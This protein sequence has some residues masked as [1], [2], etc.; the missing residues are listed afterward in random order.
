MSEDRAFIAECGSIKDEIDAYALKNSIDR[1][2]VDFDLIEIFTYIKTADQSQ[3]SETKSDKLQNYAQK[4][5]WEDKTFQI[6]QK[7]SISIYKKEKLQD[8]GIEIVSN[9]SRTKIDANI[10]ILSSQELDA[11]F[12]ENLS[13]KLIKRKAKYGVLVFESDMPNLQKESRDAFLFFQD[14]KDSSYKISLCSL[15][16]PI[17]TIDGKIEYLY[18][19]KIK[20]KDNE[21]RVDYSDRGFMIPI[22][23]DEEL[24]KITKPKKGEGYRDCFGKYIEPQ[25]PKAL[26]GFNLKQTESI[27][28]IEDDSFIIYRS[29]KNGY[30]K[31]ENGIISVEDFMEINEV[32]FKNT[33]SLRAG[34][35]SGMV[36]KISESDYL[37]ESIGE[38][39]ILE[40]T[41]VEAAGNIGSGV[42][43][44]AKEVSIGGQTHKSSEIYAEEIDI[45]I[46][47]GY[48]KGDIVNIS[49]LEGGVVESREC[50]V[51]E[52]Q[53]GTIKS[54]KI[55]I[56][57]LH[58]NS[59]I[60]ATSEI[61]IG[62]IKGED[63]RFCIDPLAYY[64][65]RERIGELQ[66]E[67]M[68]L[69]RDLHKIQRE[70]DKK[71][72]ILSK[73][74]QTIK[75]LRD[76]IVK[77]KSQ[78]QPIPKIF[79]E[80]IGAFKRLIANISNLE[81]RISKTDEI[82]ALLDEKLDSLNRDILEAKIYNSS[83]WIGFNEIKF[84]VLNPEM[85]IV[86]TPKERDYTI[87][88][89]KNSDNI[90]EIKGE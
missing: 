68:E 18:E 73:N 49:R 59:N 39:L 6:K 30:V 17:L 61:S 69:Q 88:L 36:V 54:K 60:F 71:R 89:E 62:V 44:Y 32:S 14:N 29:K 48:C 45:E 2:E 46:H 42:K 10:K 56:G 16:E 72:E 57:K 28:K 81:D 58:S 27:E 85:E 22:K 83:P 33:G 87:W 75:L 84:R 55:E 51:E 12:D 79:S 38:G 9:K 90:Y 4:E 70:L 13:K 7:Y 20:R 19:E 41:K 63:N 24:I 21:F 25:E 23:K 8:D 15:K 35:D 78:N 26:E 65:D 52:I 80:K 5:Y 11:N 34:V 31:I 50:F 74:R 66:R 47:K 53:S 1:G 43:I 40:V 82:K 3:F 37:K 67:D 86:Y 77:L 76:K 64:G